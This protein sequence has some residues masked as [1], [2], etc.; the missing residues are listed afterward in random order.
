MQSIKK[1]YGA[2]MPKSG[3]YFVPDE[4]IVGLLK[5]INKFIKLSDQEADYLKSDAMRRIFVKWSQH[6]QNRQAHNM[7]VA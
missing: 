2:L 7:Q 6:E 3:V 1:K 4:R 5:L